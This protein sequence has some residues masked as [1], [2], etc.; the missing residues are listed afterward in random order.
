MSVF[1]SQVVRCDRFKQLSAG[2][3][4]LGSRGGEEPLGHPVE[5]ANAEIALQG[6]NPSADGA[7]IDTQAGT[8]RRTAPFAESGQEH[9]KIVPALHL[10]IIAQV[11]RICA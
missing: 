2:N 4:L 7:L 10:P 8:R 3:D 1:S 5:E 9:A 6:R 11:Q